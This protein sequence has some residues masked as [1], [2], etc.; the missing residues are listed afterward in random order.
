MSDQ[1][2]AAV[3]Y[4]SN[5]LRVVDYPVPTPGADE[6]LL[7]VHSCAICGTDPKVIGPGWHLNLVIGWPLKVIRDAA[8]V[9]TAFAAA[10]PFASTT[11][12]MR[13][14]TVIMVSQPMAD[15]LNTWSITS[16]RCIVF[17]ITF[18]MPRPHW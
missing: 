4:G 3:L 6:V 11:A 2:K 18:H 13:R 7:K 12:R 1:M 8:N 17:Q 5:D 16:I 10:I 14:G 15:T 9:L